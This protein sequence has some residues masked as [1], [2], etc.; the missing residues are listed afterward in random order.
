MSFQ[1][2]EDP[3]VAVHAEGEIDLS[4]VGE[5]ALALDEA[6]R[7]S[8][9]GFIVDLSDTTYIDSAGVQAILVAY[10]KV[11][12]NNGRIALVLGNENIRLVLGVANLHVLPGM[13]VSE[14]VDSARRAVASEAE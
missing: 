10:G 12:N 1:V 9:K 6:V 8:P 11:R 3:Q 7:K 14:D 2:T 4:N 5:F 13:S